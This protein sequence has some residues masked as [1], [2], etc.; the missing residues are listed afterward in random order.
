MPTISEFYGISICMYFEDHPPPHFHV[1]YAEQEARVSIETLEI[2]RGSLSKRAYQIVVEWA[3][4]HRADLRRAWSQ[5]S[6]PS[7]IDPIEPLP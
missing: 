6:L 5:A 7:P 1:F 3:L 2:L 4:L